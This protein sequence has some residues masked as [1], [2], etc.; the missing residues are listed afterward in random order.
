MTECTY[1]LPSTPPDPNNIAVYLDKQ[2]VVQDVVNGWSFGT[3]SS[4]IVLNGTVCDRV[5]S[6]AA[7]TVQVIFGCTGPP[8]ILP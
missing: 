6:G 7:S 5:T 3:S 8:P 2:L 4:S 1:T